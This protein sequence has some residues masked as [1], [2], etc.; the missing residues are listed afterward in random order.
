MSTRTKRAVTTAAALG[1]ILLATPGLA[2]APSDLQTANEALIT[3]IVTGQK[4]SPAQAEALLAGFA[5][6]RRI[7]QGNPAVTK[8]PGTPE[9]CVER[10]AAA[11]LSAEPNPEWEAICGAPWMAPLYDPQTGEPGGATTCIDQFEFPGLPC[12]YPVVWAQANQAAALCE[13][14]GKRLCDAHEW[15]GSCA[16][17]LEPPDYRFDLGAGVDGATAFRRMRDAHNAVYNSKKTWAYGP[18]YQGGVCSTGSAKSPNCDGG[19]WADCGSNTYPTGWGPGCVSALGVWDLHGNAAEH[20]SLPT[21][22]EEMASKGSKTLGYTE[23]KG[24]WFVWDAVR[25]HEDACRWRA[26]YWHGTRVM[27]PKS[28]G[29]YHLS[30]RCCADVATEETQPD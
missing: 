29:N 19:S 30:F 12:E 10:R 14:V 26:P 11:G 23:M 9:A 21:R 2:E 8:H 16:G 28:H 7:G 22:P 17:A 24:S 3:R 13:S 5:A 25:A 4:L 20:M 6:S 18:A 15:E 1:L 27:D